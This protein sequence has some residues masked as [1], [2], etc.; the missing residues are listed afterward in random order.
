MILARKLRSAARLYRSGG[1]ATIAELAWD[2]SRG[3]IESHALLPGSDRQRALLL[4]RVFNETPHYPFTAFDETDVRSCRPAL[5]LPYLRRQFFDVAR[6]ADLDMLRD[7]E[8][9][10]VADSLYRRWSFAA[11]DARLD[12]WRRRRSG[13]KAAPALDTMARRVALRL[14]R[15]TEA[16]AG[17]S[18]PGDLATCLLR[19]EVLDAQGRLPEATAAF[20]A[21]VRLHPDDGTVRLLYGFHLLKTGRFLEGW[22]NWGLADRLIGTYPLR[23][24]KPRWRGEALGGLTLLVIFEHGL[25]D[26]I[27]M[28]RFLHPLMRAHPEARIMARVPGP[29]AGLIARSFSSIE[30]VPAE[31][32]DPEFDFYIPSMQLP[33]VIEARSLLPTIDYLR[34]DHARLPRGAG[35]RPRIGVCWRGHPRQYEATRSISIELFARLFSRGEAEFV[36]L[37]NSLTPEESRFLDGVPNVFRP[38]IEDFM[39]L[40]AL[41]ASCDLVVSVD[42]AVAHVAGAAGRPALLLSRPDACW[43]WGPEGSRT[44]WYDSVEVLRHPGDMDWVHVLEQADRRIGDRLAPTKA[45]VA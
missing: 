10:L 27:Q 44:P 22:E 37:L 1:L 35:G 40:G 34:L 20:E 4:T 41:V 6:L 5:L 21:A 16:G 7:A 14:G 19:A 9:P 17:L 3:Y 25:G 28:S 26:M 45:A 2:Q 31:A 43:R 12:E 8:I 11:L 38:P 29:L 42:T 30:V 36:V 23:K 39:G 32:M 24:R 13:T 18:A 33:L 15:L